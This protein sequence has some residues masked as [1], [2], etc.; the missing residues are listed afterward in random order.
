[1]NVD[2]ICNIGR[3]VVIPFVICRDKY[4]SY[5]T[6]PPSEDDKRR[7]RMCLDQE[8]VILDSNQKKLERRKEAMELELRTLKQKEQGYRISREEKEAELKKVEDELRIME[9]EGV[10]IQKR[11]NEFE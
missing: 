5:N 6:Q 8:K 4:M 1:M 11:M 2:I 7:K 3:F 10:R 9:Q